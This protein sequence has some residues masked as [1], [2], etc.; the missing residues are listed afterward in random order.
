[1]NKHHGQCVSLNGLQVEVLK[2]QIC[3]SS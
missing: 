2:C 1:M 3:G